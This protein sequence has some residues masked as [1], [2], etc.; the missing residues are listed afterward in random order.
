MVIM[1]LLKRIIGIA[2]SLAIVGFGYHYLKNRGVN[3]PPPTSPTSQIQNARNAVQ[4]Y[5]Q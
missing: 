4:Q 1:L 2:V 3:V 5:G